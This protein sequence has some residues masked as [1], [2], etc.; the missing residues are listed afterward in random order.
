MRRIY[1]LI[2]V[3]SMLAFASLACTLSAPS[4]SISESYMAS[5]EEGEN[6]TTEFAQ[7]E[8]I[9]AIVQVDGASSETITRVVWTTVQAEGVDADLELKQQKLQG[10]GRMIFSLVNDQ[11][12][13]IGSYAVDVY[14]DEELTETLE[15]EVQ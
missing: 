1:P 2:G 8:V 10:G 5:D 12:W 11:P 13:P 15:F 7:D 6:Q 14:L 9:Y 4:A 3:V